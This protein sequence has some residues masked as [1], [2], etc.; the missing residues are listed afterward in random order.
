M[1]LGASGGKDSTVLIH[2]LD[3]LNRSH[4]YGLD[5]R[6]LS[7]DEGISG[8]RPGGFFCFN[9]GGGASV[10]CVSTMHQCKGPCDMDT[11]SYASFRAL[12]HLFGIWL[13]LFGNQPMLGIG[14]LPTLATILRHNTAIVRY[15]VSTVRV[16]VSRMGRDAVAHKIE[17]IRLGSASILMCD[18]VP[19][20]HPRDSGCWYL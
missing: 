8:R 7:I 18:E 14:T 11:S 6:L 9:T 13:A 5:L 3:K 17:H 10:Q 1:A 16:Q 20:L 19:C 2:V 15:N 12:Y 4:D